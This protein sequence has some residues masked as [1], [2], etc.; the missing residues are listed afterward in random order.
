[1]DRAVR[2]GVLACGDPHPSGARSDGGWD[3]TWRIRRGRCSGRGAHA[4][5]RGCS[6]LRGATASD[7]R[8]DVTSRL[9]AVGVPAH[10]SSPSPVWRLSTRV[11]IRTRAT[12]R[13]LIKV[14]N[15]LYLALVNF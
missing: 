4:A 10:G 12:V 9:D 15:R 6:W 7:I 5:C 1:M 11:T 3:E 14:R 13:F 2:P 8:R